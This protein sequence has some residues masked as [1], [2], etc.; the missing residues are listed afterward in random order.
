MFNRDRIYSTCT[1]CCRFFGREIREITAG[2]Y[3]RWSQLKLPGDVD[4]SISRDIPVVSGEMCDHV[5][6]CVFRALGAFR[7]A[8]FRLVT[9]IYQ[10]SITHSPY[11]PERAPVRLS[12]RGRDDGQ[13]AF[14]GHPRYLYSFVHRVADWP[15]AN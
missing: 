12:S 9:N 2:D 3:S 8:L 14:A 10:I 5:A 7:S 13:I 11:K 4:R 1:H 15:I 6:G